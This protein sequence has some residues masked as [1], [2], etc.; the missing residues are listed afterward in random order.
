M[1]GE[2]SIHTR[3]QQ[4]WPLVG[5][6]GFVLVSCVA[7][8]FAPGGKAKASAT[9]ANNIQVEVQTNLDGPVRTK[10]PWAN[11]T[12]EDEVRAAIEQYTYEL[13]HNGGGAEAADNLYR[14]ANLYYSTLLDYEKASLYYVTLVQDYPEYSGIQTAFA[15]LVT[16]YERLGKV[17]LRRSALRQMMDYYG[18]GTEEYLFAKEQLDR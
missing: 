12:R 2:R 6:G 5:L 7:L 3:L 17:D 14:L 10:S 4:T 1:S 18:E 9:T 13:E 11:P 15:N 16:C 8:W